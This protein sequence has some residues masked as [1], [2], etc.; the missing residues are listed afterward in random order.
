MK[1]W[2]KI[3][4]S[5]CLKCA[6]LEL[7]VFKTNLKRCLR[8]RQLHGRLPWNRKIFR[9]IVIII[10]YRMI[11]QESFYARVL[12]LS[13]T[14]QITST[15]AGSRDTASDTLLRKV[16]ILLIKL[17]WGCLK[18]ATPKWASLLWFCSQN[19]KIDIREIDV[20]QVSRPAILTMI[21]YKIIL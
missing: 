5:M 9:K 16:S 2:L 8:A 14:D 17:Q 4:P 19:E 6:V 10:F 12:K 13:Q 7:T 11:T 1:P 21:L 15:P 18:W 20:L 3:F